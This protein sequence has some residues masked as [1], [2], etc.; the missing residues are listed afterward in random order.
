MIDELRDQMIRRL[1][2]IQKNTIRGGND[3]EDPGSA[4]D[5]VSELIDLM[6]EWLMSDG[7]EEDEPDP[8]IEGIEAGFPDW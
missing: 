3:P 5:A 7:P 8:V 4:K 6:R 1:D 2:S